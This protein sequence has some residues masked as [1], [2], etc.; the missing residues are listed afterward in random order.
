MTKR[1][2][3]K[4]DFQS[5]GS[6]GKGQTANIQIFRPYCMDI[7]LFGVATEN[8]VLIPSLSPLKLIKPFGLNSLFLLLSSCTYG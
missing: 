8:Q 2:G 3:K 7:H 6:F 4:Y 5:F 1:K